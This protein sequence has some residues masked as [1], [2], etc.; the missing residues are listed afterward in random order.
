MLLEASA[1]VNNASSGGTALGV[2]VRVGNETFLDVFSE[3]LFESSGI[4]LAISW[5]PNVCKTIA[6]R[7]LF[8]RFGPL[9]DIL[10]GGT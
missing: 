5:T 6:F 1:D 2:A 3:S 7:A 4:L 9:F 10:L 8:G